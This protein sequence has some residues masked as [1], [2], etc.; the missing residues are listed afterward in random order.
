MGGVDSLEGNYLVFGARQYYRSFVLRTPLPGPSTVSI[1]CDSSN[2]EVYDR[3]LGNHKL[4]NRDR[5]YEAW[6]PPYHR[7]AHMFSDDMAVS[8]GSRMRPLLH[9]DTSVLEFVKLCD[10]AK[11]VVPIPLH[12]LYHVIV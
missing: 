2:F 9:D 4:F 10:M 8:S 5:N 3:F 12:G 7:N 11:G 6:R 1:V